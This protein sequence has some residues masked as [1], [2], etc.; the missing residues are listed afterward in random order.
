MKPA[1]EIIEA[2]RLDAPY[3]LYVVIKMVKEREKRNRV[4]FQ[5]NSLRAASV[6]VVYWVEAK[7]YPL[8]KCLGA[9][10]LS[11][12]DYPTEVACVSYDGRVWESA[13]WKRAQDL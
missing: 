8:S 11:A 1:T 6:A 12:D 4:N 2:E 13:P 5:A 10:L 3:S 9:R 7:G